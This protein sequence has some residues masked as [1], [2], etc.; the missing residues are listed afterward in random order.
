MANRKNILAAG[1]PRVF[2]APGRVNIIGEHTD[3]N[4]GLVLPTNLSLYTRVTARVRDDNVIRVTSNNFR[5]TESFRIDNIAP[6]S[7]PV[8]VDYVKGVVAELQSDGLIIRGADLLIDGDI[9]IGGGLSSSAS[10]ELAIGKA[11]LGIE[12]S[13]MD[14]RKLARICQRAEKKYAGV[15]CGIMDQQSIACG[16]EGQAM[17]LDCQSMETK[18]V[19]IPTDL[20]LIVINSGIKHK[21][22]ESGYNDRSEE[23]RAAAGLLQGADPSIQSLRDASIKLVNKEKRRLGDLLYRRARH[24]VTEIERTLAAFVA[25]SNK[26]IELLGSLISA[27]HTSLRD[28]FEVSC[29]EMDVLVKISDGCEGVYGTRMVGA[30]F[31]GCALS[32]VDASATEPVIEEI[33]NSYRNLIGKQA[34]DTHGKTSQGC[35]GSGWTMSIRT[36]AYARKKMRRKN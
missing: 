17:L 23:C 12:G 5:R 18:F 20:S 19:K 13:T 31:G 14:A 28:D 6:S 32:I 9:P 24:V 16:R 4:D 27:S 30:G 21:L 10:L 33:S 11:L 15:S 26:N 2:Q 7:S 36:Q 3:Y 8:W 34:L 1:S 25:L 35:D 22:P 29:Q